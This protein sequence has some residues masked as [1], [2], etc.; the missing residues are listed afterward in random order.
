M[1][2]C[3]HGCGQ[4][5]SKKGKM[6][7]MG[8]LYKGDKYSSPEMSL[9]LSCSGFCAFAVQLTYFHC[10]GRK[11]SA[12]S[13]NQQT[14]MNLNIHHEAKVKE[15]PICFRWLSGIF[16]QEGKYGAILIQCKYFWLWPWKSDSRCFCSTTQ[17]TGHLWA[18]HSLHPFLY[19]V[20]DGEK[21]RRDLTYTSLNFQGKGQL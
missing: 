2:S 9:S 13:I 4:H 20:L 19:I 15:Y 12:F 14:T 1:Q 16:S 7:N 6:K 8:M 11:I 3:C 21:M 10:Y 17:P 5:L 18:S